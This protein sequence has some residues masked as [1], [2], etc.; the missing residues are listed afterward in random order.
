MVGVGK[1]GQVIAWNKGRRGGGGPLLVCCKAAAAASGFGREAEPMHDGLVLLLCCV[2]VARMRWHGWKEPLGC[3]SCQ[4]IIQGRI[5]SR[6][7]WRP[8]SPSP[9]RRIA[10]TQILGAPKAFAH[11]SHHP[12]PQQ[13]HSLACTSHAQTGGAGRPACA[14][15]VRF[16]RAWQKALPIPQGKHSGH[17]GPLV[18]SARHGRAHPPHPGR[19]HLPH[20]AHT[21]TNPSAASQR[22]CLRIPFLHPSHSPTHPPPLPPQPNR[23]ATQTAHSHKDKDE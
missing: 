19:A 22:P 15:A 10:Q 2:W 4:P 17:F 3:P 14:W 5:L 8:R 1:G 11:S 16:L 7:P 12:H 9:R 21:L 13:P 6:S 18:Q 20:F 23:K